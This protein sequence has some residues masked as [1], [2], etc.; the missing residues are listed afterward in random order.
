MKRVYLYLEDGSYTTFADIPDTVPVP[1][2]ATTDPIPDGME[3]PVRKEGKWVESVESKK[4]LDYNDVLTPLPSVQQKLL[5][6]Q[7]QQ[8]TLLQTMVMQQDQD[9]AKLQEAN[10]K[11]VSQIKQLQQMFMV[12]DQQQAIEKSKEVTAQ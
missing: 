3:K 1:P 7:S 2:L 4:Q 10:A 11:Q 5:M 12:A 6:Q 8:I 9:N